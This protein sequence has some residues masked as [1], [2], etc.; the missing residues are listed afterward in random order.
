MVP[1]YLENI[2]GFLSRNLID[3]HSIVED[4]IFLLGVFQYLNNNLSL[5]FKLTFNYNFICNIQS[6]SE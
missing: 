1:T 6:D 2:L 4:I 5:I 3:T